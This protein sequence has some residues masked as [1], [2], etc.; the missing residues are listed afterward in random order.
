MHHSQAGNWISSGGMSA[1]TNTIGTG[2]ELTEIGSLV[3]LLTYLQTGKLMYHLRSSFALYM[4][5]H[6]CVFSASMI[7]CGN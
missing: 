7:L 4:I 1:S 2:R 5:K 3:L 6:Q